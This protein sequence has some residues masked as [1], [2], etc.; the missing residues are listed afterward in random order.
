VVAR[1]TENTRVLAAQGLKPGLAVVLVGDDPAS[2]VYVKSKSNA[3]Q[4][5][6]FHSVQHDLAATTSEAELLALV[7]RLN[8]DPAIHGILLQLPLPGRLDPGR[9][10][11]T[12]APGKDV[13]GLHPV[14]SGR[15][16]SGD[17]ARALVPCTPAGGM[18]LLDA[19]AAALGVDLSGAEAV[20]AG[21]SN[22]VG[23]P[24][25]QLLLGRH[26]TVTVAH[27]RTRDL[28]ATVSQ[29]DV[30]VAAVGRPEMIRGAWIKQGAIVIDVGINRVPRD[31]QDAAGR[32]R[33]KL[34]GDVA[35]A[36]AI[37]RAGA[38]T[39]VPGGVGPMTIAMLMQNT[40]RAALLTTGQ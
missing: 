14:N 19:A 15:L 7:E 22:L 6:G 11:E 20:V 23:K 30:L 18:V 5:C 35:F 10:I 27:S 32:Q 4:A 39:P 8:A 33:T 38:I 37:E 1:V 16:A 9:V 17:M 36:E 28:A 2:Q 25:V 3:A 12:I 29:A 34:V 26:A 21:R 40:L 13:D 31:G 24:I